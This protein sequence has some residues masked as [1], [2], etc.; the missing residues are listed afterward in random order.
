[1]SKILVGYDGSAEARR[2]A[3][4]AADLALSRGAT[5]LVAQIV[6]PVIVP[7]ELPI[8]ALSEITERQLMD[9]ERQVGELRKDLGA[10]GARMES[11][12]LRGGPAAELL[13]IAEE[14]M[15]VELV[16]VGRSGKGAVARA[17]MG[18]V[19]S[20]LAHACVK[21]VLVVP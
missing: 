2:A 15:D 9:A 17:L 18:S 16:V 10:I 20:R 14:N 3:R 5:L 19:S 12:V 4:T 13:R 7:G 21:P 11:T 1:M 8:I 6:P